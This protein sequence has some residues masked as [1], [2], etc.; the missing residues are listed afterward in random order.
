MSVSDKFML[1]INTAAKLKQ[2]MLDKGI[3]CARTKCPHCGGDWYARLAGTKNH[4]HARCED[5]KVTFTE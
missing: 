5:C 4:I 1:T 3:R 2:K